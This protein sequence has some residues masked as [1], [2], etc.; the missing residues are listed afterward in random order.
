MLRFTSGFYSTRAGRGGSKAHQGFIL[1]G[2]VEEGS[3]NM[4]R[5]RRGGRYDTSWEAGQGR[6]R[7][8][9]S[10]SIPAEHCV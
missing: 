6:A 2:Q 7:G 4:G 3:Y 5:W 10:F 1:Q 9:G 8:R